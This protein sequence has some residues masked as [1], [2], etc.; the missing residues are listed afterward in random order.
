L[1]K[2]NQVKESFTRE[3][4]GGTKVDDHLHAF[5]D[6]TDRQNP[7]FRCEFGSSIWVLGIERESICNNADGENG[8]RCHVK[9]EAL[10]PPHDGQE[11]FGSGELGYFCKE[12][13][14]LRGK[15]G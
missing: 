11:E 7:D 9:D 6:L 15:E 12:W 13:V 8:C 14:D 5:E 4:V 2:R 3:V 1:V 10:R